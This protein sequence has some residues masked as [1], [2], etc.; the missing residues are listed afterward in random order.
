[1]AYSIR[2]F[3]VLDR[4]AVRRLSC[5]TAFLGL[6]RE[7]IFADDEVLA[8]FL[9]LYFTDH[10]PESCLVAEDNAEVIGYLTGAK[11]VRAMKRPCLMWSLFVKMVRRRTFFSRTNLRFLS[12][13][14]LSFVKGEFFG[15]DFADAF[16]ATLHINID[17]RYRRQGVGKMLME[18][19]L[20]LLRRS[21]VKGVHLSTLSPAARDFFLK[22]GFDDLYGRRR[23]FL[24][25]Y[26]GTEVFLYVLGRAL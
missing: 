18:T 6:P 25:P 5:E 12:L 1:M 11:D 13:G 7:Q 10:E 2:P 26:A 3:R 23:T 14:F 16:P 24:E 22:M 8:D 20:N 4:P 19:Y 17:G 15:K 21:Q 9:T